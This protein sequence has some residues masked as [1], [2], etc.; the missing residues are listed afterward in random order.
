MKV[1][2]RVNYSGKLSGEIPC[3]N[4]IIEHIEGPNTIFNQPMATITKVVCWVAI[5]E[6]SLYKEDL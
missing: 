3:E 4:C 1:G 6:L 5:A 2:D